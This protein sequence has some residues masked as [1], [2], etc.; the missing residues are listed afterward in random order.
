M[1]KE[2][3]LRKKFDIFY[4]LLK[5]SVLYL[6][7]KRKDEKLWKFIKEEKSIIKIGYV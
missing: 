3:D 4:L 1:K 6:N 2:Y 7:K 5:I